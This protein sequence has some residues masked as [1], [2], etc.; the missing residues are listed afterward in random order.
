MKLRYSK[1]FLRS[2]NKAPKA[3]KA[4]FDKQALL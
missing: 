3:I 4:A 2:Y 1:H